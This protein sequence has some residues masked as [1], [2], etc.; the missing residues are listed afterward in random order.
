[1]KQ[2]KNAL[3]TFPD[4][5][6]KKK[7]R[8][9]WW[10]GQKRAE[11]YVRVQLFSPATKLSQV[12][13]PAKQWPHAGISPAWHPCVGRLRGR[14]APLSPPGSPRGTRTSV[15]TPHSVRVPAL[16]V[17]DFSTLSTAS[18]HLDRPAHRAGM[19]LGMSTRVHI[20]INVDRVSVCICDRWIRQRP[21]SA[22]SEDTHVTL[23]CKCNTA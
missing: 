4:T 13:C 5:D 7:S 19:H 2:E 1:M 9:E 17:C 8:R 20:A 12:Q 23:C 11:K 16:E 10:E 22:T 18:G 6:I 15:R 14:R 21:N 3:A